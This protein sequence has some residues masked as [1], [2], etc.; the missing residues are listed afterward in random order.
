MRYYTLALVLAS[1]GCG[2]PNHQPYDA[3]LP[4]TEEAA[5][6]YCCHD[7]ERYPEW[8]V[9]W[10]KSA[11][12]TLTPLLGRVEAKPGALSRHPDALSAL[13][14]RARPFD[15]VTV[16][17]KARKSGTIIPGHFTHVGLYLGTESQL[18][19]AGLWSHRAL[20]PLQADI[21]AGRTV[22][23]AQAQGI[24]MVAPD[25]I[26]NTDG[27]ALIRPELTT[28]ER[29]EAAAVL[30]QYLGTTFD[31]FFDLCT[32]DTV[33]CNELL[34]RALP[35]QAYPLRH[36]YGAQMIIP[37]DVVAKAIRRDGAE[38]VAYVY[39]DGPNWHDA[40]IRAVMAHIRAFWGPSPAK[41]SNLVDP[42]SPACCAR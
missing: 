18:R 32:E 35:G 37:D 14:A 8:Y 28:R 42:N 25:T 20:A 11:S 24:R 33:A 40:G 5:Q 7:P 6:F 39:S 29:T 12:D 10:A 21:R 4:D 15:V 17:N 2:L 30:T 38:V 36:V 34:A 31:P 13:M 23:E 22:A 3:P 26:L 19:K 16:S 1:A 9:E 41:A 27:A